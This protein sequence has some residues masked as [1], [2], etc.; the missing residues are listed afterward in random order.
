MHDRLRQAARSWAPP[1]LVAWRRRLL[2]RLVPPPWEFVGGAW[3]VDDPRARGWEHP[4]IVSVQ[5]ARWPAFLRS[6]EGT[7]PLGVAHESAMPGR[8]DIGAHNTLMCAAYA[9]ALAAEGRGRMSLLDWGGGVGHY[10]VLGRALLPGVELDYHCVDLPHFCRAG[11][12]LFPDG[13]FH[14]RP[15][16]ALQRRYDLVLASSSLQYAPDW[17]TVLGQLAEASER[18]LLV[19]RQPVVLRVPSFVAVQRP[20]AAGY[21]ADY[22]GWFVN[23]GDL[24]R[25]A[26]SAGASLIREFLIDEWPWVYRA[27]EQGVYRGFLFRRAGSA[28]GVR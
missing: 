11:E 9:L 28:G 3:P 25:T 2:A 8:L 14:E 27:P 23:R 26:E 10:G 17:K 13:T 19:T 20:R 6:V 15:G 24:L 22:L 7:G 16:G 5:R 1:A 18:Y 12:E 4:D 21:P